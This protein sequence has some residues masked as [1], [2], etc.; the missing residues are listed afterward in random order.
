MLR[1]ARD[2]I[3]SVEPATLAVAAMI[4]LTAGLVITELVDEVMDPDQVDTPD[5]RIVDWMADRASP[6]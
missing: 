2:L 1:R 4:T 6:A 3:D 5:E